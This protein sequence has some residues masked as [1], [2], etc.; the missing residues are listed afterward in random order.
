MTHDYDKIIAI[1]ESVRNECTTQ[2][3]ALHALKILII[4]LEVED[5]RLAKKTGAEDY[6]AYI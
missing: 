2:T 5:A 3:T 6:A 1:V 4:R